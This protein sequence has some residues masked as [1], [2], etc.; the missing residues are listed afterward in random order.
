MPGAPPPSSGLRVLVTNNTLAA[1]AGSELYAR[2]IAIALMKQGH[3]PVAY[4][5]VL[6]AVAEDLNRATVPVIDDLRAL[7]VPPDI[8]H[9]HH[10]L[11]TMTAVLH[12]PQAPAVYACHGW[13]PWE[14]RPPVFPSIVR[15]VA[16]DDLCRERLL[17][18]PGIA[19]ASISVIRNFVDLER[20][21]SRT[22]WRDKPASALVFSNS[23]GSDPG[24]AAIKAACARAG[25]ERIDVAGHEA[26]N[27]ITAPGDVLG[28]YDV[29]FA[30]ARCA[31]EAMAS[32]AAVIVAD[33][34]GLGGLVT[35]TNV[36]SMRRLNFGVRTMQAGA[37][38]EAGVLDALRRYDPDDAQRVGAWI[39]AE[40]GMAR[41]VTAWLSVYADV[42]AH[43][44]GRDDRNA[45]TDRDARSVAAA[46]YLRSLAPVIKQRWEA[47]Y[48]V[49][50]MVRAQSDLM[51]QM[52]AQEAALLA[53]SRE[54]SALKSELA[55]CRAAQAGRNN[56]LDAPRTSKPIGGLKRLRAWLRTS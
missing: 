19:P 17:T 4:S 27:P 26:G 54:A 15:Y 28:D 36:E 2:D 49:H 48:K 5:P 18:T 45:A 21:P 56:L 30:K 14:E 47:E 50:E 34:A 12:F 7:S 8:I 32:G 41:A 29:V 22:H 51:E 53:I 52:A 55:A 1:R 33:Q 6:G 44:R 9:G 20:F 25:I 16:V 46:I 10:H 31:L 40:A 35:T 13:L 24:T 39:R 43:W 38:T 3:F 42:L 23:A 11:E 37:I